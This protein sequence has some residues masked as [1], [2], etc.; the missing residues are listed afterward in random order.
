M[1]GRTTQAQCCGGTPAAMA[2]PNITA[3]EDFQPTDFFS[4][5]GVTAPV[6]EMEYWTSFHQ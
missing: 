4:A 6:A 3:E 2:S 5:Q 1:T